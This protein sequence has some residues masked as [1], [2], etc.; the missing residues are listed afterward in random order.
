MSP[1]VQKKNGHLWMKNSFIGIFIVKGPIL[2]VRK[3]EAI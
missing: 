2:L 3:S 1:L